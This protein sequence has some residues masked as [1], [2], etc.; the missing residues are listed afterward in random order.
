MAFHF[1]V[2]VAY[3][4]QH[5]LSKLV[6]ADSYPADRDHLVDLRQVLESTAAR[7]SVVYPLSSTHVEEMSND[8]DCGRRN[9]II[10]LLE[11][12]SF[13]YAFQPPKQIMLAQLRKAAVGDEERFNRMEAIC[14]AQEPLRDLVG[15]LSRTTESAKFSYQQV[16]E[17]WHQLQRPNRGNQ[18]EVQELQT[19]HRM[20]AAFIT[21]LIN[22]RAL[23]DDCMLASLSSRHLELFTELVEA[24]TALGRADPAADALCFLKEKMG[25][26]PS[27]RMEA[28]LWRQFALNLAGRSNL[29]LGT[30]WEVD[31][32]A[33]DIIAA[34]N[35]FPYCDVVFHDKGLVSLCERVGDPA[36]KPLQFFRA[37]E[38]ALFSQWLREVDASFEPPIDHQNIHGEAGKHQPGK[39]LAILT[40][41]S[42]APLIRRTKHPLVENVEILPGGGFLTSGNYQADERETIRAAFAPLLKTLQRIESLTG[43]SDVMLDL[44]VVTK[45]RPVQVFSDRIFAGILGDFILN[46][47]PET[48]LADDLG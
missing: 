28:K 35:F 7:Q 32:S 25:T 24:F 45:R 26:V 37:A 4:D 2:K 19:Y 43:A 6:R 46:E 9:Q 12:L 36:H 38:F 34:A 30:D 11:R 47:I 14:Y 39:M 13:G 44:F 18:V 29:A 10:D 20:V 48:Y 42:P 40:P 33:R 27:V 16:G 21:D 23:P 41:L 17:R 1:S 3:L 15:P 31:H 22:G 8:D 5:L